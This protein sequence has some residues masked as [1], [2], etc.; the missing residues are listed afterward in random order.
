MILF[1]LYC[2]AELTAQTT[3]T[4][5]QD[6]GDALI[7]TDRNDWAHNNLA[8]VNEGYLHNFIPVE[9]PCG[10]ENAT[11]IDVAITIDITDQTTTPGCSNIVYFGN[12]LLNCDLSTTAVCP[13]V[14]DVLSFG[15]NFG[16]GSPNVGTYSLG[17][18]GCGV[19]PSITDIIG[20]DIIPASES[21]GGSCPSSGT[22]ISDNMVDLTYSICIAYT[23]IENVPEA[24][25]NTV[26]FPCNDDNPCTINDEITVDEC[27]N[28]IICIPCGGTI[29]ADCNNVTALPCDDNDPCTVNDEVIV[30]VCDESIICVPC[31]GSFQA[32]CSDT[33]ELACDDGDPCTVN[34]VEVVSACDNGIVCIPCAG[35][36]AMPCT[37]TIALPCDDGNPCTVNDEELVEA[38]DNSI[39]CAPCTGVLE[40]SCDDVIVLPCNDYDDCTI[41]DEVTVSV[42]DMDFVC[43]PCAGVI[44]ADCDDTEILPCDDGDPCTVNDMETVAACDNTIVCIPCAGEAEQPCNQTVA[45]ACD[46]GDPCTENDVELR[47][48]CFDNEVCVPCMGTPILPEQCD[49]FDCTNGIESWDEETC[50]CITEP[51]ILGCTDE[52]SCNYDETATCDFECDYSCV[53]CNGVPFGD[54]LL[55]QCGDCLSP[56]DPERDL[57]CLA[58]PYM[59][60]AFT[61]DNDGLND[62]FSVV[63]AREFSMFSVEIFNR[64]GELVYYS[65]DHEFKW[66]GNIT[67]GNHFLPP[68]VYTVRLQYTLTD[69]TTETVIGSVALIR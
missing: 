43:I 32:D 11:L 15:C 5:C 10:L 59:P 55:D 62:Y 6:Q 37:A 46:D 58:V 52:N 2:N 25:E 45:V 22:V 41:N 24:C 26:T 48:A 61:P 51:T 53:D 8:V 40:P 57:S 39:I 9:P 21:S 36:E 66:L 16:I 65:T 18:N 60:N 1:V 23:F 14:Q 31:A 69:N 42:C 28:S 7:A 3:I 29:E 27:D 17:L 4:V 47:E 67:G 49:D 54:W 64:W 34:D 20:V 56:S 44:E 50:S 38:C 12:V 30:A 13:I 68:D 35:S 63:T 19:T 33:V